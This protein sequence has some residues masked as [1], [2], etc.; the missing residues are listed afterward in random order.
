MHD[1]RQVDHIIIGLGLSGAAVALQLARQGKTIAV[2]DVPRRNRASRVAAGLFNPVSGKMM[3]KT[4]KADDLFPYLT[5]FYQE[6]EQL[7]GQ[8]FLHQK[9]L[10]IP[11]RTVEEQ[12]AWMSDSEDAAIKP[13]VE[14]VFT[15]NAFGDQVAD[16]LGGVLLRQCGYLH[17]G[18]YLQAV[19]DLLLKKYWLGGEMDYNKLTV[20]S[21]FIQY[22]HIRAGSLILCE[23]LHALQNPLTSWLPLRPLKGETIDVRFS[24]EP[25][26]IYNRGVY[27]VPFGT[28]VYKVGA[29]FER[30]A[31]SGTSGKGREE[32]ESKLRSLV[33]IP[34]EVIGHDWGIRPTV[35]D[36]RPIVGRHPDHANVYVF[37]GMG[38]KAVSQAPFFSKVLAESLS[39][40]SL[41]AQAVNISRFYTLSSK[42]RD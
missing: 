28:D 26:A 11:F 5:V 37:N 2:F 12:N 36:R 14:K 34:Y 23:G 30:T 8:R 18:S 4:W 10:Y 38:T 19:R 6:A 41:I 16:D 17:I 7:T 25:R 15:S 13:Y 21:G 29:T 24:E 39:H 32:L 31:A 20:H 22:E 27:A 35:P 9:P 40:G 3:T 33:R 1:Q 42:S